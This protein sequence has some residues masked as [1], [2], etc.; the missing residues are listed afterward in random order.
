MFLGHNNICK[1]LSEYEPE[2][3]INS[4]DFCFTACE[5]IQGA[6]QP[7]SEHMLYIV[8]DSSSL[9]KLKPIQN[10][11]LCI[12]APDEKDLAPFL[13]KYSKQINYTIVNH[14][15]DNEVKLKLREYF[16]E[17]CG[18]GLVAETILNTI[19]YKSGIQELVDSFTRAFN[20]PVYVFD[21]GFNLVAWTK[22]PD[23]PFKVDEKI[24]ENMGFTADEFKLLNAKNHIHKKVMQSDIPVKVFH[25]SQQ[26]EQMICAIDTRKDMGHI[27]ITAVTRPFNDMDVR[28]MIMLKEGI[29]QQLIRREFV[30]DNNGYPY[31]YFLKDIL[32]GKIA[33][34]KQYIERMNYV[35][36]TFSDS[37]YCMVVETARSPQTLNL[38]MVRS[39]LTELYHD[40]KTLMYNGEIIVLFN[41]SKGKRFKDADLKKIDKLCRELEIYAGLSN[42]FNNLLDIPNYYKQALRAIEIG[43][44]ND[45]EPGLSTYGTYYMQHLANIFSLKESAEVY[46]HPALKQLLEYDKK[47]DT[48]LAESLY[49]YLAHERNSVIA[50][51]ALF[52]HRNTLI[53]RLKKIDALVDIDYDSFAERQYIILSYEILNPVKDIKQ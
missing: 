50:A 24:I 9:K 25:E 33:T 5:S 32:D 35:N 11:N 15:A 52:I 2:S 53:Y 39:K 4:Y 38:Y 10:M 29:Y 31:E 19:F 30:R 51:E 21:A 14:E 6:A 46:C 12:F 36:T 48:Q 16:D 1:V 23:A 7:Y 49:Q 26:Y 42:N 45:P 13:K 34:P 22:D 47:H 8:E 41:L 3:H 27:V 37:L 20:N 40:T 18:S 44:V 28:L 17:T 43:I